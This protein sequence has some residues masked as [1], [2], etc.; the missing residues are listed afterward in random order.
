[1]KMR[2]GFC[3]GCFDTFHDGHRHF[4]WGALAH[5]SKLIVAVNDDASVKTLKGEDRPV[6]PL[7]MR[8][9]NVRREIGLYDAVVPFNGQHLQLA[10][11][12]NPDVIIRGWDQDSEN[13]GTIP[14][15][16]ISQLPGFSTTLLAHERPRR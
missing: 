16:R 1:M 4:L 14:V 15:V 10:A 8:M 7:W 13:S 6:E 3:T 12:I 5:C 2:I 9:S 11:V